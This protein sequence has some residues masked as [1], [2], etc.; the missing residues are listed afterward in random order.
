MTVIKL[1]DEYI[2]A[3]SVSTT[4]VPSLVTITSVE[5]T[6]PLCVA[7]MIYLAV[8]HDDN[9]YVSI[10]WLGVV[11]LNDAAST[12]KPAPVAPWI[13]VAPVAPTSP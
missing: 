7:W 4:S 1:D 9:A 12:N 2:V 8:L 11:V 5:C 3:Y 10:V 13:P 6:S